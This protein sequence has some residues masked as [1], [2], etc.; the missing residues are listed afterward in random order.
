MAAQIEVSPATPMWQV[1][2]EIETGFEERLKQSESLVLLLFPLPV[3]TIAAEDIE[4]ARVLDEFKSENQQLRQRLTHAIGLEHENMELQEDKRKLEDLLDAERPATVP[5]EQY[6]HLMEKYHETEKRHGNM[7]CQAGKLQATL[8]MFRRR[9]LDEKEKYQ[10]AK[11]N[12]RGWQVFADASFAKGTMQRAELPPE[13]RT[14]STPTAQAGSRAAFDVDTPSTMSRQSSP[15]KANISR[16]GRS[17]DVE[18]LG[19]PSEEAGERR[20]HTPMQDMPIRSIEGMPMDQVLRPADARALDGPSDV[21]PY[22]RP[23]VSFNSEHSMVDG[24]TPR[25]IQPQIQRAP[26]TSIAIA[27]VATP[28]AVIQQTNN[29]TL[30]ADLS[31]ASLTDPRPNESQLPPS[32]QS[33]QSTEGETIRERSTPATETHYHLES[34][35]DEP[36]VVSERVLKRRREQPANLRN[37]LKQNMLH[38]HDGM[39]SETPLHIK[40]E[41]FVEGLTRAS[42]SRLRPEHSIDDLDS[43]P[44]AVLTPRKYHLQKIRSTSQGAPIYYHQAPL[45]SSV[46][47]SSSLPPEA[48]IEQIISQSF[49]AQLSRGAGQDTAQR[50]VKKEWRG[51]ISNEE[52]D[53]MLDSPLVHSRI[54]Q[55][56][57]SNR[58]TVVSASSNKA[59][60]TMNKP[61]S[62]VSRI[63]AL[64]EDGDQGRKKRPS[65]VAREISMTCKPP[66]IQNM[67]EGPSAQKPALS[68]SS[69]SRRV[70]SP[71]R[72]RSPERKKP[73]LEVRDTFDEPEDERQLE[74]LRAQPLGSLNFC[75]FKINPK[76]NDGLDFAF[77]E[78]IRTSDRRQCLPGCTRPDCCGNKFRKVVEIGGALPAP[79]PGLWDTDEDI[80]AEQRVLERHLGTN[81]KAILERMSADEVKTMLEQAQ[82]EQFAQKHGR[83]KASWV[84]SATPPGFWNADFP[85]TQ[86]QEDIRQ[87]AEKKERN[88]VAEIHREAIRGDGRWIFRDE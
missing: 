52:D 8:D 75:D 58:R 85:S 25:A 10:R 70:K 84:R 18:P 47:R 88:R 77:S 15:V 34:D 80:G 14:S 81:A 78:V 29:A 17:V 50:R 5:Y 87:Q 32:L 9:L 20:C 11:E 33:T 16:L 79:R 30:M 83:H 1:M 12:I 71:P 82:A 74:P 72:T 38:E 7:K 36:V 62:N 61:R 2:R 55:P 43:I 66:R 42:I 19:S 67:L 24:L 28:T 65:E 6:Q 57:S 40:E 22:S 44:G 69:R 68:A 45:D 59:S 56:I 3:L 37:T 51:N 46:L 27:Q 54:L 63:A 4:H 86:E 31:L 64:A 48:D 73:R 49:E 23:Q 39:T 53:T 60:A 35:E 41:P 76:Y 13:L 26:V 21:R